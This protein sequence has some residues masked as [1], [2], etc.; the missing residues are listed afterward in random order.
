MRCAALRD[1]DTRAHCLVEATNLTI[2]YIYTHIVVARVYVRT[3]IFDLSGSKSETRTKLRGRRRR[4]MRACAH[5]SR[6]GVLGA[7]NTTTC[8]KKK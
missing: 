8:L 7:R 6:V 1:I 5:L 4:S 3:I 2:I